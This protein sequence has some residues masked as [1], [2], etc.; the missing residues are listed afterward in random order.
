MREKA[1]KKWEFE[2]ASGLLKN[3]WYMSGYNIDKMSSLE[4]WFMM[5]KI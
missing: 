3:D 2:D 1:E 5:T 4:K